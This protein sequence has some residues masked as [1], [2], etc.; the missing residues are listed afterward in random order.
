[1]K[2]EYRI[3]LAGFVLALAAFFALPVMAADA[4]NPGLDSLNQ[5][6]ELQLN[7]S[8]GDDYKKVIS[9]CEQA[10]REGLKGEN[11]DFCNQ[12]LSSAQLRIGLEVG[13]QLLAASQGQLPPGWENIRHQTLEYLESGVKSS[14]EQALPYF[15]IA[16]LNFSLPNGN[17]ERAKSAIDQAIEKSQDDKEMLS[18]CL[19]SKATMETENAKRTELLNKALEATPES[20]E[21]RIIIAAN[22][23]DNGD[24]E[25]AG[26]MLDEVLKNHPDSLVAIGILTNIYVRQKKYEE[27]L[28]TLDLLEKQM[29]DNPAPLIEKAKV[30]A[31]TEKYDEA[32]ALLDTALAKDAKNPMVLL[33]RATTY[34][35][36]RDF[37]NAEKDL[38]TLLE[39]VPGAELPTLLKVQVLTMQEKYEEAIKVLEELRKSTNDNPDVLMETAIVYS[40][41]KKPR[42]ALELLDLLVKDESKFADQKDKLFRIYRVRGDTLLSVGRHLDAVASYEKAMAIDGEN[43]VL[44]NNLAWV[45]A[46]SPMDLVRDGKRSLELALKAAEMTEEKEAFILSTLAAA[47]AENADF[48]K[49]REWIKKGVALAGEA[50]KNAKDK[51]EKEQIFTQ[52]EHLLKEQ[53]SYEKSEP[54]RELETIDDE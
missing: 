9:L 25:K 14:P 47:Y 44:I 39:L 40:M 41:W 26:E 33:L 22:H 10:K 43:P 38:D 42:K 32:I 52:N 36:K 49:A 1:M 27:A 53:K 7:A 28:K 5:A 20:D 12:L 16:Q 30:L 45:L 2:L 19:L 29:P 3:L 37:A 23:A 13:R 51:Y 50:Y 34:L 31:Q 18:R 54:W 15:F 11:L 4:D 17:L 6:T 8:T 46:T 24:Y 21:V 35:S 48:E